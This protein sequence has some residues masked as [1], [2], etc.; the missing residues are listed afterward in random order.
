MGDV[1]QTPA[2]VLAKEIAELKAKAEA[3]E[4]V[5]ITRRNIPVVQ[6]VAAKIAK[7]QERIPG[8]MKH[9]LDKLPDDVFLEQL[10]EEEL[11]AW[12]GKV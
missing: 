9:L 6:L 7:R 3:G 12:E 1:E 8:A 2:E 4:E 5:I 10:T 11:E